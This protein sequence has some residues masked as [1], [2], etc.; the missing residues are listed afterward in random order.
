MNGF[1][2]LFYSFGRNLVTSFYRMDGR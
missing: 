2:K 1:D